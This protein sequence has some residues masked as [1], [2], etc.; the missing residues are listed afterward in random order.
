MPG[1]AKQLR[2]LLK[3]L[4]SAF[5]FILSPQKKKE[6][7]GVA[8]II[9]T[10]ACLKI[11]QNLGMFGPDLLSCSAGSAQELLPPSLMSLGAVGLGIGKSG[12]LGGS[13]IEDIG[14]QWDLGA[15]Q[16]DFL[17]LSVWAVSSVRCL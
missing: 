3:L 13:G 8:E 17:D 16:Q 2:V 14:G 11:H 5:I 15:Q 1:K 9:A 4:S 6:S 10:G 12:I 7:P